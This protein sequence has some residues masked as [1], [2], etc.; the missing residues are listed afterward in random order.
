MPVTHCV[1]TEEELWEANR[2]LQ[3]LTAADWKLQSVFGE[4]IHQNDGTHHDGSIDHA[5][6]QRMQCLYQQ[7]IAC[8][9]TLCDLPEVRWAEHFLS[10]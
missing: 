1:W 10:Q 6:D 5:E 2:L 4:T 8:R 9:L 7:V 3:P